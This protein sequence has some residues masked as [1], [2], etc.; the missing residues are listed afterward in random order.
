MNGHC[1]ERQTFCISKVAKNL[2]Q[3]AHIVFG[4]E[5]YAMALVRSFRPERNRRAAGS[6]REQKR[7]ACAIPP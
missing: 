3:P 4:R 1:G 7:A 2:N 6:G 5:R